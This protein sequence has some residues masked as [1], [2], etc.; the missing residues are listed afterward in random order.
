MRW[1]RRISG[2][3]WIPMKVKATQIRRSVRFRLPGR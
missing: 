1:L 3:V 2:I